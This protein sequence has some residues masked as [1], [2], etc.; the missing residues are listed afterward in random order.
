M[1]PTTTSDT[2]ETRVSGVV[3]P[4]TYTLLL[5]LGLKGTPHTLSFFVYAYNIISSLVWTQNAINHMPG[6]NVP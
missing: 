2:R 4:Q 3:Q 1:Q 6:Y 5:Y